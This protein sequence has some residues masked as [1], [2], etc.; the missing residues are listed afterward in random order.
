VLFDGVP[1]PLLYVSSNQINAVVP[2]ATASNT[3]TRMAVESRRM[4]SF[5][6]R[7]GV[8]AATPAI[9]TTGE[10]N[11][12]LRVAAAINQDGSVN[13][14]SN[15]AAPGSVIA[16]FGTGFGA[17]SPTPRDGS[18]MSEP[19]PSLTGQVNMFGGPGFVEV[20]YAGPAPGEVAGVVQVNFRVPDDLATNPTLV[21]FA[22]NWPAAY[23]TV[24]VKS[25]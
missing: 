6:A 7:L 11:H 19:L 14:A 23:F 25:D 15:A 20:L 5:E 22:A 18:L 21:L 2:F 13:S 10:T 16:V 9:F 17:M 8:G 24:W 12:G 3:E 4:K 1:A